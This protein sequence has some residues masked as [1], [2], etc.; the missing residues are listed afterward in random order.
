MRVIAGEYGGRKLATLSAKDTRPTTDRVRE[1]WASTMQHMCASGIDDAVMLDAF[2]GSGALGIEMLSRNALQVVFFEREAQAL[3]TLKQNLALLGLDT[4]LRAP[5]IQGDVFSAQTRAALGTLLST[6]KLDAVI[7]DPPYATPYERIVGL[8]AA[9]A[10][11]QVLRDDCIISYEHA[12]ASFKVHEQ[13]LSALN[14]EICDTA[15]TVDLEASKKYG[16]IALDYFR[17]AHNS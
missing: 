12:A 10:H 2:A 9:L 17:I 13:L 3:R 8:L 6:A 15:Y 14:H 16:T 1:A 5:V 4:S 11:A 7:L